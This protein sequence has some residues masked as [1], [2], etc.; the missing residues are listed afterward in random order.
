MIMFMANCGERHKGR[1][2]DQGGVSLERQQEISLHF[3]WTHRFQ[4]VSLHFVGHDQDWNTAD[5]G[6]IAHER[7]FTSAKDELRGQLRELMSSQNDWA[8]WAYRSH[9]LT[10][11]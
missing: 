4:V 8:K 10:C 6:Q 7:R 1:R 9:S 11:F 2:R 3:P 5:N